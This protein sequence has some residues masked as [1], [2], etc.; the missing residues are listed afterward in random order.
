MNTLLPVL[1]V[2]QA[3][4]EPSVERRSRRAHL[5][6]V[7]VEHG[8]YPRAAS[9]QLRYV[10]HFRSAFLLALSVLPSMTLQKGSPWR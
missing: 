1:Q 2:G 6:P 4:S 10:E 8:L 7:M 9:H 5:V 3:F